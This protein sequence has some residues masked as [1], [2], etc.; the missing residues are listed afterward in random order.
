MQ[1]ILGHYPQGAI[2]LHVSID[3]FNCPAMSAATFSC[4]PQ[5]S[6][7]S[8]VF[9]NVLERRPLNRYFHPSSDAGKGFVI[10]SLTGVLLQN[11]RL[12]PLC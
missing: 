2:E 12:M 5:Q 1:H 7:L 8:Q 9:L 11:A 10:R 6:T 3:A 4:T